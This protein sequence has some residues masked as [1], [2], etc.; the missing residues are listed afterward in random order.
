MP[1]DLIAVNRLWFNAIC[2]SPG[3]ASNDSDWLGAG[4]LRLP[5]ECILQFYPGAGPHDFTLPDAFE[6]PATGVSIS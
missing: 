5:V 2:I 4:R 6:T 1:N 3:Y